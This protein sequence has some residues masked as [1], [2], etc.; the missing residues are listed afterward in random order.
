MQ[1]LTRWVTREH[2]PGLFSHQV[3]RISFFSFLLFYFDTLLE[4]HNGTGTPSLQ[5]H[6]C[7]VLCGSHQTYFTILIEIQSGYF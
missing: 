7:M 1:W 5:C 4:S 2:P 6:R 3:L